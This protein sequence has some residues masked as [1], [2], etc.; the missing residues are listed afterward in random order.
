MIPDPSSSQPDIV[1]SIPSTGSRF[2]A[3]AFGLSER[4]H[5]QHT[6]VRWT[7]LIEGIK[8]KEHIVVPLRH[9]YSVWHSWC[10]R[11]NL[12]EP[13][14]VANWFRAWYHLHALDMCMELDV[15]PVDKR[16]DP[17]ITSW[18][19]VGF[20]DPKKTANYELV[21][22]HWKG[23]MSMPIVRRHYEPSGLVPTAD[24]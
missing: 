12:S 16:E 21:D 20:D 8:G 22:V 6:A 13:N 18:E 23:L 1:V 19:K 11:G 10:S 7:D 9:P 17:R 4:F 15:V 2:L 3:R 14:M 5:I 24:S